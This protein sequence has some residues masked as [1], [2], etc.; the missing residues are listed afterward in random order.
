[1]GGAII[2]TIQPMRETSQHDLKA[3]IYG[4]LRLVA[5]YQDWKLLDNVDRSEYLSTLIEHT[6]AEVAALS[7]DLNADPKVLNQAMRK[8]KAYQQINL[9][10]NFCLR[11]VDWD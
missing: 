7:T 10:E 4:I 5:G 3:A 11:E 6:G 1:M 9:I 8:L 2:L